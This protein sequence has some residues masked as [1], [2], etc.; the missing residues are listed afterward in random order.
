MRSLVWFRRDLRLCDNRALARAARESGQLLAV[1]ILCRQ[2]WQLHDD[3]PAKVAFWCENLRMLQQS[4]A[5]L[6]I[7]L[8]VCEVD[9]FRHIPEQIAE[10]AQKFKCSRVYFNKEYEVNEANR[11]Q[12]VAN[13]L[14]SLNIETIAEHDRLLIE[15]G[16]I[17]TG[18]G[19][20]YRV[21]TPFRN[22]W[23]KLLGKLDLTVLPAPE[24]L[25]KI[26][27]F[28]S[29]SGSLPS[30][31][32]PETLCLKWP[33]GE[34]AA[35]QRL[36]KFLKNGLHQYQQIRDLPA[37]D[38]TSRLSAYL[39][40]GVISARTCLQLCL[41]EVNADS[42]NLPDFSSSAGAWLNE[43]VWRDFYTHVMLAF[44]RVSKHLPFQLATEKVTWRQDEEQL[45][46][47][48][49]GLTGYPFVD[50]AM[51][52]L[53]HTGWMHNRL[54]MIAAMFLSKHLLLDWRK[55][56]KYFM[57]NLID[58][59][60]AANNGGWQWSAST[61]TDAAPYFRVFNP[62]SQS[63]KFDADGAFIKLFC[64]ELKKVPARALHDPDLLKKEIQRLGLK[65]PEPI[66][67][68]K[69]ARKRAIEAFKNF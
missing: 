64:P 33:A 15:P 26:E 55:G 21:F 12:R 43:L 46:A 65:Y 27:E 29:P 6:N 37:E 30:D 1:F 45:N 68:H 63:K 19:R 4:L 13:K 48:K 39:S 44:P 60:L 14:A 25:K 2:Q 35:L 54:R 49:E 9:S 28:T 40:A 20:P 5:R 24:P 67:E 52:Q 56:E 51:R 61:G 7:E 50:A 53:K 69:W 16:K 31:Q 34:D 8:L 38:K 32:L 22:N 10:V 23:T 66:V 18:Q 42:R 57:Q 62:F 3:A 36:K 17:L 11:D 47:W 59:D 41:H 58:G